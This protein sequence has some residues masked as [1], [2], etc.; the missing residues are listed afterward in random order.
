MIRS[1]QFCL[2]FLIYDCSINI[3]I[4]KLSLDITLWELRDKVFAKNHNGSCKKSSKR[5]QIKWDFFSG[6]KNDSKQIHSKDLSKHPSR[7]PLAVPKIFR[8]SIQDSHKQL[9]I[10][11]SFFDSALFF[12]GASI[13]I[14]QR[15]LSGIIMTYWKKN[16]GNNLQISLDFF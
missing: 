3:Y 10:P 2:F 4:K 14:L 1:I 15:M 16:H 8:V 7:K 11:E 6:F 13:R 9:F 5:Y 12:S